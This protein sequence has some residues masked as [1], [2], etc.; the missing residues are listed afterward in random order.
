MQLLWNFDSHKMD[1]NIF[2]IVYDSYKM[3]S[4][5]FIIVYDHCGTG[6]VTECIYVCD[7][8]GIW[9]VRDCNHCLIWIVKLD[10]V[11]IDASSIRW[12]LS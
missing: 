9:I 5:I 2:L 8:C 1:S 6:V 3:G 10:G 12:L 4:N 11:V 7:H